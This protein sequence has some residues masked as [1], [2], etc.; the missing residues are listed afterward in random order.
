MKRLVP[1]FLKMA[2][3][4]LFFRDLLLRIKNKV[5]EGWQKGLYTGFIELFYNGLTR[6]PNEP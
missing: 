5:L 6:N 1:G 3:Q 4:R 2:L